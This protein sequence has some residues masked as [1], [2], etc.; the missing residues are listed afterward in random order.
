MFAY[1]CI[2]LDQGDFCQFHPDNVLL[3]RFDHCHPLQVWLSGCRWC[4]PVNRR[5]NL[6]EADDVAAKWPLV[7]DHSLD[8][9]MLNI[10][11]SQSSKVEMADIS[12]HNIS[13]TIWSLLHH[14]QS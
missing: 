1:V 13:Y 7:S 8:G 12:F 5:F 9:Q 6:K 11:K 14:A 10:W 3:S 4:F 2:F